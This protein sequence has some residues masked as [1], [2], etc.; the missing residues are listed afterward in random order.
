MNNELKCM[1]LLYLID[2]NDE[3]SPANLVTEQKKV[4]T[5]YVVTCILT[6]LCDE[7]NNI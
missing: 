7:L 1:N 2:N 5:G 3:N 6:R 4:Q